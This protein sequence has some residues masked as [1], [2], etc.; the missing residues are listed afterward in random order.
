MI[1]IT[2][3]QGYKISSVDTETV[4]GYARIL[5]S[6]YRR[7]MA[8][9]F[10]ECVKPL[11]YDGARNLG[12][13]IFTYNL[14]FDAQAILKYLDRD[15][16]STLI[17]TKECNFKQYD[18]LFI[19]NKLMK[20]RDK[21]YRTTLSFYDITQF[22]NYMSLDNAAKQYLGRA[23]MDSPVVRNVIKH[24]DDW[25]VETM[26]NYFKK[27]FTEISKYCAIDA[28]LTRD[29]AILLQDKIKTL[30][31]T[32]LR[33]Y[34]SKAKIAEK[35]TDLDIYPRYNPTT[36]EALYAFHSF[37]GGIFDTFQRGF[38]D[39]I[40]EID[41]SSAYPDQMVKLENFRN[42]TFY[43]IESTKDLENTDY[44]GWLLTGFDCPY[45]P[46]KVNESEVWKGMFD[47]NQVEYEK[48][49][50]KVYYPDGMRT[51]VITLSEYNFLKDYGYN[52][53]LYNGFV[54][55]KESDKWKKPFDWIPAVYAQKQKYDKYKDIEY[56][57]LKIALNGGY[58][59]TAQRI[60]TPRMQNFYYAS[61]ITAPTRVK[62][63]KMILDEKLEKNVISIATDGINLD[64]R[65]DLNQ[66]HTGLGSWDVTDYTTGVLLG[67]GMYQLNG[68]KQ[69]TALRG[70]SNDRNFDLMSLLQK[71]RNKTEIIPMKYK[72]RPVT[73]NMGVHFVNLYKVSDI[74]VFLPRARILSINGDKTKSW[75]GIETFGDLLDSNYRGKRFTVD[76]L[77][78]R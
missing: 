26:E 4:H 3:K 27:N 17:E 69:K 49:Y 55:R 44:Y 21:D 13:R 62:L 23:K 42:G 77:A 8:H 33:N 20:I 25:P 37:G 73:L 22:Y 71:N 54:W 51:K 18:I 67:N 41:I 64:K 48:E 46:H 11:F 60:G 58:G 75:E 14:N 12:K 72:K 32:T 56:S 66:A 9:S 70:V 38:F 29:L 50:E 2:R 45:I 24:Q 6:P 28:Q 7:W 59:K 16:L 36:K 15:T 76:E 43:P 34:A 74:N 53:I 52:P 31:N 63:T 5:A 30:F 35:L 40:T 10:E 1:K 68:K 65:V 47:G 19:R 57:L 78:E 39:T 61:Y